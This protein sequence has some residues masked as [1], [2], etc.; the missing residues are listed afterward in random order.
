L[1]NC[2]VYSDF[3]KWIV[4]FSL[5]FC[6]QTLRLNKWSLIETHVGLYH[7]ANTYSITAP[8]TYQ[9]TTYP[10]Q[11]SA[12]SFDPVSD[13]LWAG[14]GLGQVAAYYRNR[15]R[16]VTFPVGENYVSSLSVSDSQIY[17]MTIAGQGL[18]AWSRGGVNKWHHRYGSEIDI[19]IIL[20]VRLDHKLL[21]CYRVLPNED[22]RSWQSQLMPSCSS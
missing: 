12:L 11:I 4:C 15:M 13:V 7:M 16:G 20:I 18:G 21:L 22:I 3:L 8:I 19:G 10:S 1:Y 2:T 6:A 5:P 14:N 17:A 9:Q